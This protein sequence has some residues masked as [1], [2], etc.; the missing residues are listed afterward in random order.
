VP[1]A[2]YW[3]ELSRILKRHDILL[4]ADEVI[5]GFGRTG[6]W[7]GSFTY[8]LDP[9]IMTMAKG[10][11]SGYQPISAI[12]LGA[13]MGNAIASAKEELVHGYTCS[14][15]PVA[16]AVALKNLE[17]LERDGMVARVK[18]VGPYFQRR[19]REFSQAILWWARCAESACWPPWSWWRTSASAAPSARTRRR[20]DL[21]RSL[22]RQ[23][24]R[25]ARDPRHHGV[26]TAADHHGGRS[27]KASGQSQALYR[28]DGERIL[29]VAR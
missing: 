16:S 6:E 28:S 5:T 8:G 15:H 21:P 20:N 18:R 3:P 9:D 22:L 23:W 19:V 4:H 27:G 1:P 29:G 2:S 26:G 13:R 17:V 24:A 14:G 25:H 12:S 11:S 7:F 10:L